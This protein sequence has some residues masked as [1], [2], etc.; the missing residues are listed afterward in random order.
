MLKVSVVI[1]AYN[2]EK[3]IKNC[4]ESLLSQDYEGEYEIIVVD[5][6]STDRTLEILKNYPIKVIIEPRKGIAF[7]RQTGFINASGDIILST[8]ADTIVPKNWIRKYVEEFEKDKEL[9]GI[10]GPIE[11][12]EIFNFTSLIFKIFTPFILK[13]EKLIRGN[14][15]FTGA[16]FAVKKDAFLKIGGFNTNFETGEDIDLGNRLKKSW[17]NKNNKQCSNNIK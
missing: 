16:N 9:V 6:G 17:E 7:A 15:S 10:N 1:P 3:Y 2:E 14:V 13:I 11:F 4:I 8:D 5:N 12:K